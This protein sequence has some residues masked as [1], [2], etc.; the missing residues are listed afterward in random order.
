LQQV[1]TSKTVQKC[2]HQRRSVAIVDDKLFHGG[3]R[4]LE[5]IAIDFHEIISATG[6]MND[7]CFMDAQ[8]SSRYLSVSNFRYDIE[9]ININKSR[10]S[11]EGVLYLCE[12]NSKANDILVTRDGIFTAKAISAINSICSTDASQ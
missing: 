4:R 9:T 6:K 3:S 8:Q 1:Y 5:S 2:P 10:V 11:G 7:T 12:G